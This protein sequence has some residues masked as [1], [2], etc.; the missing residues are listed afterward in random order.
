M[1]TDGAAS[2]N[3]QKGAQ[4]GWGVHWPEGLQDDASDVHGLDESARLPGPIQ[5]NNRAELMALIRACQLC[6]DA[7]AHLKIYTDS[8]YAIQAINEWQQTW[9]R[10]N[11]MRG[12]GKQ[13]RAVMNKDLIR[14]LEWELRARKH[15]PELLYVKGHATSKGNIEADRLAVLGAA[16]P[17]AREDW[18]ATWEP[19]D[20]EEE[21]SHTH[22][23]ARLA[24]EKAG[25]SADRA[26]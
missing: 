7:D 15:R 4:A 19:S 14:R 26:R 21:D 2:S 5:T 23:K 10:N 3:G 16:L 17:V 13:R 18:P 6:P 22:K 20:S 11:W 25:F 8:K 9:R 1:Y 24:W 12:S